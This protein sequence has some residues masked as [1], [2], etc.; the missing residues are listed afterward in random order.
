MIRINDILEK[1]SAYLPKSEQALIQKAYVFSASAHAG[2]RRL[3]GEPYLSHPLEVAHILAELRLDA[4]T[5]AAGLLHDTLEDT[6]SNVSDLEEQFGEEV[7]QIV[8]GVTK[9]GKVRFTSKEEAQA[10]NIRKMILAMAE[11]IRV[12][13]VKLADRL[14]NMRTL[15]H[16]KGIKQRLISQETMEIYAPLANRLGL[17]RVKVQ[18]E[19]ISFQY[20]RPDV[21]YQIK[22]GVEQHQTLGQQYIE[23]V[24]GL[25]QSILD[26]NSIPGRVSGRQKHL[27]SIFHKM[28]RQG[29][30]LDQVHDLVAFRVILKSVRDCYAVLGLIHSIWKPV[31][32]R[33]KDYI[34]MPKANM[35]QSLHTTV[36]GPDGERIEIQIRTEEMHEINEYGIAAHWKYKDGSNL[37][38]RDADRFRWLR[39]ILDWQKELKDP[40]EFMA[41]LRFDL[42]QDEVYVFTPR[43][44]VREL[45]DEATPVDFA[46]MIHTEVGNHCAGAKVN[47]KL[48]PLDTALKNGDTVEI[49]TDEKRSPSRDWL[50]FVKTA[51]A[52]TRIK[53]WIRTEERSRSIALAKE[54]LEKEGRRIGVN[55]KKLMKERSL[56][57]VAEEYSFRSV[58][59]LLSAVGYAKLTPR[60]ILNRFLPKP[61]AEETPERQRGKKED[62]E[63]PRKTEGKARQEGVNIKGVDDVLVRFAQC[64]Q[65]LPGDPIVGYISRGRGVTVHKSDCSNVQGLEPERLLN[66]TWEGEKQDSFPATIQMLCRNEMGVLQSIT[67]LLTERQVNIDSG[68][69]RSDVDGNSEVVL[70]V[71]VQDT[72][73][74]YKTID[75]ISRIPAVVEVVRKSRQ[76]KSLP[77]QRSNP[78]H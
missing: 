78:E 29:L 25:I 59:D 55:F 1:V 66:V 77:G 17:Y 60:Q 2:Q 48:V 65:P 19:D 30:S 44:E 54:M 49:I 40:R 41:S 36:I 12:I 34:S 3:S 67:A 37:S 58:D 64:C 14:H 7:A 33:F 61:V 68:H 52:R 62:K 26:E 76:E 6:Q 10:E 73:H 35:Y 9:I 39:Q 5:I 69:F 57:P 75:A 42:F 20:L 56:E 51:K 15:Q 63:A 11:D 70:T 53:H 32:G 8:E 74:L 13:I 46:Y 22:S 45:P 21:Y 38:E 27:Y 28:Q 24:T 43:G 31:P 71:Q 47:G 50:K 72:D 23:R 4:P 16:Q 18:L